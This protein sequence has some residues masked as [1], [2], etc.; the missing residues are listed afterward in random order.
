MEDDRRQAKVAKTKASFNNG[1]LAQNI[2]YNMF[3]K[4]VSRDSFG[5]NLAQQNG[6]NPIPSRNLYI[7]QTSNFSIN[8]E[9]LFHFYS[10]AIAKRLGVTEGDCI[11]FSPMVH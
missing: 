10:D 3:V 4:V 8:K 7:Q 9:P 5:L 2:I 1:T 11:L 6:A